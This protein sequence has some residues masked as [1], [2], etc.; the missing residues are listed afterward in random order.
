VLT[1][2]DAALQV[3][4]RGFLALNEREAAA[5]VGPAGG[6]ADLTGS[7]VGG[8][9]SVVGAALAEQVP[10]LIQHL[11]FLQKEHFLSYLSRCRA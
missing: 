10:S 1:S 4:I 5:A 3:L 8:A 7:A 2:V 6:R 11:D 9:A